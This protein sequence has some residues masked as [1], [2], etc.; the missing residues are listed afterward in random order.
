MNN[1]ILN[2]VFCAA[3]A[4]FGILT[5]A[6]LVKVVLDMDE[7]GKEVNKWGEEYTELYKDA[8]FKFSDMSSPEDTILG[9]IDKERLKAPTLAKLYDTVRQST[10]AC[11][12]K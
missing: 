5:L 6:V 4:V 1:K 12:Y 2:I 11:I 3:I 8:V 10:T 7:I 9:E